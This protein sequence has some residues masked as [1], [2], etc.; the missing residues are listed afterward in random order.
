[1]H[2]FAKGSTCKALYIIFYSKKK[3][4]RIGKKCVDSSERY[5]DL[6][7]KEKFIRSSL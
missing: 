6:L 2:Q 5:G 7:K 4:I 1:M 3:L